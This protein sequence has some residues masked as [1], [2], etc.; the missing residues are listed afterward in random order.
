MDNGM[1]VLWDASSGKQ[2]KLLT[3]GMQDSASTRSPGRQKVNGWRPAGQWEIILWICKV[4][5]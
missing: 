4:S 5:P 1:V 3:D 2:L